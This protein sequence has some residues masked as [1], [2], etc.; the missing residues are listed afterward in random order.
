MSF[1][2]R[3]IT[4][5]C[6]LF[7]YAP[8]AFAQPYPS[9]II[10]L[11]VPY[12]AGGAIDITGR[13]LAEHLQR[14]LNATI[15]VENKAGAGGTIGAN[16]V[17]KAAP[18]GYTILLSGAATHAFAP[19]L[20]KTLPYDP[21]ADFTPITQVSEGYLAL[22]VKADSGVKDLAGFIA[23]MKDKGASSNYA[24]NGFGTYPHLAMELLKQ[25]AEIDVTH[26][27]FKGGNESVTALLGGQ[28]Q[29]TLNHLPVVQ[30]Q[31]DAGAFRI[32][33]T[34]GPV[35]A[36][37]F[38]DAPTLK[39]SGYDVVA[40]AWF[41]LFAPAGTPREIVERISTAVARVAKNP[42]LQE[43]LRI[44]GDEVRVE[45]SENFLTLQK[46]ELE[47]WKTVIEKAKIVIN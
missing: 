6:L 3:V 39:E 32:L 7:L 23:T 28:V 44:Q 9:R 4:S 29:A 17:A 43:K 42:E 41:G 15:I 12:P 27:P 16:A 18:D 30:P 46:S 34:S 40:S 47:K 33:A 45:G 37:A 22:T 19:S 1:V 13:L 21:L 8:T 20:F 26:V 35:R 5:V 10:K 24:S 2:H 25:T 38:P 14:E 36:R 31:V 11:V